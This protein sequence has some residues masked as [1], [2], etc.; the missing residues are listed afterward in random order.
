VAVGTPQS[1][2]ILAAA[3]IQQNGLADGL[4][5]FGHVSAGS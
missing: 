1:D 2:G 5:G 4:G 3:S